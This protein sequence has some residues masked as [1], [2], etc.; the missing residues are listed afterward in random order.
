M[1][2][3]FLNITYFP[4]IKSNKYPLGM[5]VVAAAATADTPHLFFTPS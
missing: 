2:N 3:A 1:Q 5:L 4:F